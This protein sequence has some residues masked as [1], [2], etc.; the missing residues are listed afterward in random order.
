MTVLMTYFWGKVTLKS[1]D[2]GG[3][4]KVGWGPK[5]SLKIKNERNSLLLLIEDEEKLCKKEKRKNKDR[6]CTELFCWQGLIVAPLAFQSICDIL[7]Y[8]L[9]LGKEIVDGDLE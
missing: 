9:L 1:L 3:C 8:E 4:R 7:Q 6:N 2:W 5:R